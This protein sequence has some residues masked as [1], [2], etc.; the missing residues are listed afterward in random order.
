MLTERIGLIRKNGSKRWPKFDV[1]GQPYSRPCTTQGLGG[2][3][4]VVLPLNRPYEAD[5]AEVKERLAESDERKQQRK[6]AQLASRDID[7]AE[8]PGNDVRE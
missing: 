5:L 8:Q 6:E 7:T 4:F 2:R 3:R 1:T